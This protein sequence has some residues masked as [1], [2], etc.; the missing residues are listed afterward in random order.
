MEASSSHGGLRC[1]PVGRLR[2]QVSSCNQKI[3][4]YPV[5]W[6]GHSTQHFPWHHKEIRVQKAGPELTGQLIQQAAHLLHVSNGLSGKKA[7]RSVFRS[8]NEKAPNFWSLNIYSSPTCCLLESRVA[9]DMMPN[10]TAKLW[11]K[12]WRMGRGE[13]PRGIE[14]CDRSVVQSLLNFTRHN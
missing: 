9:L 14:R 11:D 6:E 3:V 8:I 12:L 2:V 5:T 1:V 10:S 7:I 4:R 13:S